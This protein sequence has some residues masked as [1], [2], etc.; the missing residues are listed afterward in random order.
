MVKSKL[1][2]TNQR[3]SECD[4]S[5]VGY[6]EYILKFGMGHELSWHGTYKETKCQAFVQALIVTSCELRVVSSREVVVARALAGTRHFLLFAF[7][8][9]LSKIKIFYGYCE[10]F[11]SFV[12]NTAY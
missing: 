3:T 9:K 8:L 1:I 11:S 5:R 12:K 2:N 6:I 7:R 10:V 4:A